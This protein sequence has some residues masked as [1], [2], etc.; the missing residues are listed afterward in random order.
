MNR[1]IKAVVLAATMAAQTACSDNGLA[2]VAADMRPL[3]DLEHAGPSYMSRYVSMGTSLT[4]GF[5]SDG[6]WSE[7]Q[8]TSWT[9]QLADRLHTPWSFPAIAFPGCKPPYAAPLIAFR[10]IDGSSA[11]ESRVCAPNEEG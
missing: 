6:V 4:M 10:R 11:G 7:S 3:M 1:K 8:A 2:P 5:A 9:A